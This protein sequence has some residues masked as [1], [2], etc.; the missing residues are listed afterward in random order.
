MESGP[1]LPLLRRIDF[2]RLHYGELIAALAEAIERCAEGR[3]NAS[4][5]PAHAAVLA[6]AR[7]AVDVPNGGSVRFFSNHGDAG[8]DA[9]ADLLNSIGVERTAAPLRD[10]AAAFHRHRS[11]FDASD[12]R[13]GLLGGIWEFGRLDRTFRKVTSQVDGALERWIR[14]HI[15][16][17]ANDEAGDPI[18]VQFT[19]VVEVLQPNGLVGES[20][21]V[22]KGKSNGAYRSFFDDGTIRKVVFYKAGIL[23]GDF[24]PD[25][26]P[27]RR[28]SR[29][30]L[31]LQLRRRLRLRRPDDSIK[32][33]IAWRGPDIIIEWYYPGGAIQK[34]YVQGEYGHAIEPVRLYHPNGRLAE[35]VHT[36]E[37][38][39]RGPW[40]KFFDD[41]SPLLEAEYAP[42][43]T[44]IVRNAWASDR[45]QT[46]KDGSGTFHDDGRDIN[47]A[48][49]LVRAGSLQHDVELKD[50][51]PHGK[52]TTYSGGVL[53]SV[54]S[55]ND[56]VQV[57]ESTL[58]WDNGRVR[59]I[60]KI[61]EGEVV[62]TGSFPKCDRPVP[63]VLLRVE[64]N[65]DLYAA[66]DHMPVDEYPEPLNLE[67]IRGLLIVPI[68]LR[69]VHERN[70]TKTIKW[71]YHDCNSFNDSIAYILEVDDS[72]EVRSATA[73]G[74][75]FY[76]GGRSDAYPPLLRRIRFRPARVRGRAV[77]CRVLAR[78]DHTFIEGD[79][80]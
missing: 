36:V 35:E 37:G 77:E 79:V 19:G 39:R 11:A 17:L 4:P 12:P 3:P 32:R 52:T 66:W 27:K 43:G 8:V 41:G 53:W 75:G 45:T 60:S 2:F 21:E 6:W 13:D 1:S 5:S 28:E 51:V 34:R 10:A 25:G 78:V 58:Y 48:Y 63:A 54:S 80:G 23:T 67:E 16:E 47:A 20:L 71:A 73:S 31:R 22:T 55:Y 42:D 68:F 49:D 15:T 30:G 70:L 72:G 61:V 33:K 29:R 56:G 69:E 26:T 62:E 59:S 57:G 40:L 24:W 18:D 64:A 44:R 74:G 46:V 9:L 38:E 65:E 76:S 50:G 7:L 14:R